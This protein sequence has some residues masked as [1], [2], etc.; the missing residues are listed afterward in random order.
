MLVVGSNSSVASAYT[1]AYSGSA[2]YTP[3]QLVS[4]SG[5]T[6]LA[7]LA[8]GVGVAPTAG[9]STSTWALLA[10]KGDSGTNGVDGASA[11]AWM[12]LM[13]AF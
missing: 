13:G 6:Y 8:A 9:V 4:F 12:Y 10:A 11:P 5:G 7:L 3:G 1:G 2:S